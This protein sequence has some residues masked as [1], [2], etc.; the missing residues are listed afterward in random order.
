MSCT[1]APFPPCPV[2]APWAYLA[3]KQPNEAEH[4]DRQQDLQHL[5]D[6]LDRH[7]AP[8]PQPGATHHMAQ[9]GRH[10]LKW[11]QHTEFV[12]YTAYSDGVSAR[13]FDPADFEV[14]PADWLEQAPGQRITS[15]MIRVLP[16]PGAEGLRPIL[17]DWLVPE[18]LAVSQVLSGSAVVGGDFRIDPAGHMRFAVFTAEGTGNQRIGRIVQAAVRN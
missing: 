5:L 15:A 6:L 1:R 4:R 7:G 10:T 17:Q 13:A 11:E 18:S 12:S 3:V 9:I 8:H 16:R 2:P 14:F